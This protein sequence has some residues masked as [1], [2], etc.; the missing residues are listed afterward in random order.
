[1]SVDRGVGS[2]SGSGLRWSCEVVEYAIGIRGRDTYEV[3]LSTDRCW[4]AEQTAT[5]VFDKGDPQP[6]S[7]PGRR[8]MGVS[9]R[10]P[11]IIEVSGTT[12]RRDDRAVYG[13]PHADALEAQHG[14]QGVEVAIGVQD[15]EAPLGGGGGDQ[16]VGRRQPS[17]ARQGP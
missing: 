17:T 4:T 6:P 16:V 2:C 13:S 1:M 15:S 14:C 3:R 11:P 8:S 5:D 7:Y 9:D 10:D 12:L